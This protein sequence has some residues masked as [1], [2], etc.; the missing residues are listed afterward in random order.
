MWVYQLYRK[1][2]SW[3][4]LIHICRNGESSL[5]MSSSE[6]KNTGKCQT[7]WN[8]DTSPAIPCSTHWPKEVYFSA[9]ALKQNAAQ[10]DFNSQRK[11]LPCITEKPRSMDFPGSTSHREP[12]ANTGGV[13]VV[14]SIRGL[15]RSPGEGNSNTLQYTCL[16]NPMDRGTWWATVHRVSKSRT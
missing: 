10:T 4:H 5:P 13:R 15:G 6:I 12:A 2:L 9:C 14:G 11:L 7:F 1:K 8:P 16:E 3:H